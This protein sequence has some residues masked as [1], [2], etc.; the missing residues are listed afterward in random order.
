LTF[1]SFFL[2]EERCGNIQGLA[3]ESIPS[4]FVSDNAYF[5]KREVFDYLLLL[6]GSLSF[7]CWFCL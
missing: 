2:K 5:D 4:V 7:V 3:Q 1:D 6:I